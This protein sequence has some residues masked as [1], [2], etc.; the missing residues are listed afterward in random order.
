MAVR[1]IPATINKFAARS[2]DSKKKLR[3]AGYA[4]VS[5]DHEDQQ[6]SYEA[7]VRYYTE[8]IK[9]RND[10]EFVGLYSDEGI[11]A[12][13]TKYREGFKRMVQDAMEGKIDLIITK[14]VSR[15][16]RNTVDSLSTIRKLKEHKV[17]CYFEKENIWTFDSKGELLITIMSSLAQEESRSISENVKWGKRKR[18]AAGKVSVPYARFLG[19]EKG[20]DG[21]MVVV[22]EQAKTVKFIYKLFLEGLGITTI[23][24]ELEKRNMPTPSGKSKWSTASIKSI[25]QNEKYKGDALLQKSYTVDFL[26]KKMK[27]NKGEIPQYYVEND[28]EAIIPP[29]VFNMVQAE[30]ARRKERQVSYSGTN[31]FASRIQCGECGGWYGAKV[32]HSTDKYRK[33]IYQCN[34]KFRKKDGGHAPHLSEEDIK[35]IFV[36]AINQMISEKDDII[37]TI[38]EVRRMLCQNNRLVQEREKA[39]RA[40]SIL[41]EMTQKA[42]ERNARVVQDQEEYNKNYDELL[43]KYEKQKKE[44]D[45]LCRE[46]KEREDKYELLGLF[47]EELK[48]QD[49]LLTDFDKSLWCMLVEKVIIRR[50][51]D[52][53]VVFKDGTEIKV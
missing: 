31:I 39:Q 11:S 50:R 37:Q 53:T 40:L 34:N 15:F 33:T 42:I 49:K 7:Q 48:K 38:E 32:W 47:I 36:R 44:Y 26:T 10:W 3:V 4:R 5:T 30:F 52:A 19:Y 12:T 8:Y 21:S 28:H 43:K 2:A 46:I 41:V 9:S 1:V 35:D 18:F 22:P 24:H 13:N 16:A 6:T 29:S 14:S 51:E 25:L 23:A 27:V 20:A 17:E 45:R